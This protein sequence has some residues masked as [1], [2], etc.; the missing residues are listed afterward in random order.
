MGELWTSSPGPSWATECHYYKNISPISWKMSDFGL[1]LRTWN[2][3]MCCKEGY[4]LFP[5][6]F[7]TFLRYMRMIGRAFDCIY[8]HHNIV[9]TM[10]I[11]PNTSYIFMQS[12]S[13]QVPLRTEIMWMCY[14]ERHALLFNCLITFLTYIRMAK[15]ALG[16]IY[17]PHMVHAV[18]FLHKM[19]YKCYAKYQSFWAPSLHA[20]WEDVLQGETYTAA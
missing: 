9:H 8:K 1:P 19:K 10:S 3:M 15:R 4:L 17:N 16:R 18:S 5:K 20:K 11:L 12:I 14:K 7:T 6:C 13:F 2:G